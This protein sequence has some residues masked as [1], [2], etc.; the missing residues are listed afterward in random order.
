MKRLLPLC[1]LVLSATALAQAN[2]DRVSG[3][4]YYRIMARPDFQGGIGRLGFWNLY[5]RLLN[6]DPF[7]SLELKLD[8]LQA[9]P[10]SSQTTASVYAKIEGGTVAN[11]DF[12]NGSLAF[13]RLAQLYAN[14]GNV[15]LD[16]VT[17]RL[18]TLE[19]FFG[20]D[21]GLYDR[22]P[23][24]LFTDTVGLLATY[25][26]ERFDL[27]IGLGDTGFATRGLNYAPILNVGAGATIRILP[28]HLELGGGAQYAYEPFV[29]GNRN[30]SYVTPA[31]RVPT[32][33]ANDADDLY[34]DY[35]RK[36]VVKVFD[37]QHPGFEGQFGQGDFRP[38][39]AS[40]PST[41]WRAVGYLGFGDFGPLKWNKFFV[42]YRKLHP[43]NFYDEGNFRI[44]I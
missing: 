38:V 16:K 5:G 37:Q 4:G 8:V 6:E 42:S 19:Y 44:Y 22:K 18:G 17:W 23:A 25:R 1:A 39:P 31:W 14:V 30:S 20:G 9:P 3:G 28:G 43:E 12:R 7:A 34:E 27:M 33:K 36:E 10:G 32:G 2:S 26:R 15:L 21:L 35:F 13:F 11:A 41:S 40:Q 24:A 29:E